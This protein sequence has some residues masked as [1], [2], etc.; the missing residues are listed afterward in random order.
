MQKYSIILE[1]FNRRLSVFDLRS[2][3]VGY[4]VGRVALLPDFFVY[5]TFNYNISFHRLLH[6]H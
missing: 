6:V 4:V 2:A 5:L 3:H 1:Y